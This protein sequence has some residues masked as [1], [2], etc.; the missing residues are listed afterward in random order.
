MFYL[1]HSYSLLCF[2]VFPP[3]PLKITLLAIK[4]VSP[5]TV[6]DLGGQNRHHF[7]R[8]LIA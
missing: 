4:N 6:F 5:P 8:N 3:S 2:D 1:T 7:V